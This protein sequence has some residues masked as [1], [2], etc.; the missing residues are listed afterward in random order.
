VSAPLF[1]GGQGRDADAVVDSALFCA[2]LALLAGAILLA[3]ACWAWGA[4]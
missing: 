1:R 2:A 3:A 4:P